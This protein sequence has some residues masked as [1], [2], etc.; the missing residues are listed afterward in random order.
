MYHYNYYLKL[1]I[2]TYIEEQK[3]TK[4]EV[5]WYLIVKKKTNKKTFSYYSIVSDR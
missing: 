5:E 4:V 3:C 2:G 1:N